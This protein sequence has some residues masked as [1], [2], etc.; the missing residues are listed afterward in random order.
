M[1]F[2]GLLD[3]LKG[4]VKLKGKFIQSIDGKKVKNNK[5]LHE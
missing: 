3:E 4:Q 2:D 1:T 5:V